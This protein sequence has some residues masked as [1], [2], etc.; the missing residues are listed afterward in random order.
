MIAPMVEVRPRK[1]TLE[2][3][4]DGSAPPLADDPDTAAELVRELLIAGG[5]HKL[6][7]VSVHLE[8]R[9]VQ[10]TFRLPAEVGV[11]GQLGEEPYLRDVGARLM[12][13]IQRAARKRAGVVVAAST[14]G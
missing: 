12:E 2:F 13:A 6:G 9:A 10:V 7:I 14:V 3:R 4:T 11:L 8:Y 5:Q 1:R